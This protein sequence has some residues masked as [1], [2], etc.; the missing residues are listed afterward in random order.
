MAGRKPK[1]THLKLITGN[2][3][4]RPLNDNEPKPDRVVPA[5][6]EHL[7]VGAKKEWIRVTELLIKVG[8]L[9]VI[10]GDALSLYCQLYSDWV[11]LQKEK[12]KP[13]FVFADDKGRKNPLMTV[14]NELVK[15]IKALCSEFGMTPSS[16]SRLSVSGGKK[17]NKF[18]NI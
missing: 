16:R 9:T 14:Q 13:G 4:R 6:P 15:D 8:I 2:P 18:D 11:D 10:D 17:T 7:S 3:G 5:C 1:P 12:G